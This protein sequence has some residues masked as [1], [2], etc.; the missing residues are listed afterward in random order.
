M[1]KKKKRELDV[2]PEIYMDH[3]DQNAFFKQNYPVDSDQCTID[4]VPDAANKCGC[5][6]YE[7]TR[8]EHNL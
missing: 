1:T 3:A 5:D 4:V 7:N 8:I 2:V 6:D